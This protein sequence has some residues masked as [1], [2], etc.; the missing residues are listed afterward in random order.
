MVVVAVQALTLAADSDKVCRAKNVLGL[1]NS[2]TK[3]F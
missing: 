2:D 3:G 1:G